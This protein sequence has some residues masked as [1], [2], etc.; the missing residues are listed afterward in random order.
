MLGDG[1]TGKDF[2]I[3]GL[4]TGALYS[5]V[6]HEDER[7]TTGLAKDTTTRRKRSA[8]G[9]DRLTPE[10][11]SHRSMATSPP[12]ALEPTSQGWNLRQSSSH[13]FTRAFPPRRWQG[14]R[15]AAGLSSRPVALSVGALEPAHVTKNGGKAALTLEGS[16]SYSESPCLA[17][18]A[19]RSS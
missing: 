19:K 3:A 1:K 8:G 12:Y 4:Y 10:R 15:C 9:L 5:K 11:V 7:S 17:G 16:A 14:S 13:D 6:S 18:Y 2:D